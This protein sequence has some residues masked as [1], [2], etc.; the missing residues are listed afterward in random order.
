VFLRIWQDLGVRYGDLVEVMNEV[1]EDIIAL[2]PSEKLAYLVQTALETDI[3][4]HKQ[5][6]HHVTINEYKEAT[7]WKDKLIMFIE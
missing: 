2:Y 5:Q 7:D 3:F 4:I 6:Y 1:Y